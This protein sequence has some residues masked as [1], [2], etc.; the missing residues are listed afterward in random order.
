MPTMTK[1]K[2][3]DGL[4]RSRVLAVL[5]DAGYEGVT[6]LDVQ[7]AI[8]DRFGVDYSMGRI[9]KGLASAKKHDNVFIEGAR[10]GKALYF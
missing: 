6:A 7:A 5:D 4:V 9:Y 1:S 2:R 3:N 10:D 8:V